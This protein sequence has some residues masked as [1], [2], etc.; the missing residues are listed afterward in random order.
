LAKKKP[1]FSLRGQK[2][3]KKIPPLEDAG[4]KYRGTPEINSAISMLNAT[5]NVI[6][7]YEICCLCEEHDRPWPKPLTDFI[8]NSVFKPLVEAGRVGV[9]PRWHRCMS[10]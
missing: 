9:K 2:S 8:V 6:A 7:A 4:K 5:G 10:R 3:F 1:T